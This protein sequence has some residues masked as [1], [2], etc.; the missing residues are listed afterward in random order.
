[1]NIN[2]FLEGHGGR[3][4]PSSAGISHETQLV[5]MQVSRDPT[6]PEN[7]RAR[8]EKKLAADETICT[9]RAMVM[10]EQKRIRRTN[11][12]LQQQTRVCRQLF[13]KGA[14]YAI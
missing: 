11:S 6:E 5:M 8:Q 12:E 9:P 14:S 7:P 2:R 13:L 3:E 4:A 1:V 10:A